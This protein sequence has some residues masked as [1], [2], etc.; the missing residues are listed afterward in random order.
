MEIAL[1][2]PPLLPWEQWEPVN[3]IL[4]EPPLFE[5][6]DGYIKIPQKP[7]LGI[8]FNEEALEEYQV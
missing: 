5:I 1:V 4:K 8:E 3:A 2:T 7:G 6:E